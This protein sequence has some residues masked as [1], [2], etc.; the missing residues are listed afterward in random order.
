MYSA[1]Y[2]GILFVEGMP[3]AV[4]PLNN[5]KKIVST[6]PDSEKIEVTCIDKQEKQCKFIFNLNERNQTKISTGEK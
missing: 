6:V 1:E 2:K 4:H 5:V 3:Y